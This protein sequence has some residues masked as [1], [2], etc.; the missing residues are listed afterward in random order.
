MV[1]D[2]GIAAAVVAGIENIQASGAQAGVPRVEVP[3]LGALTGGSQL[4]QAA[5]KDGVGGAAG[6]AARDPMAELPSIITVEVV[7]YETSEQEE[8]AR[9][10]RKGRAEIPPA[11]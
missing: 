4:A 2:L 5:A 10:K 8:E 3:N 6:P 11:V 7:G 9:R 1:G